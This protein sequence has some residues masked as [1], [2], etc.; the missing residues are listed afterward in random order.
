MSSCIA[1]KKLLVGPVSRRVYRRDPVKPRQNLT[2]FL[3]RDPFGQRQLAGL[4]FAFVAAI[5]VAL[6]VVESIPVIKNLIGSK[7]SRA[8]QTWDGYKA[9]AGSQPGT[10][11]DE[12]GF[13]EIVKG[14]FDAN[15]SALPQTTREPLLRDYAAALVAGIKKGA[16]PVTATVDQIYAKIGEPWLKTHVRS[17]AEFQKNSKLKPL[18]VDLTTRYLA[19]LPITR[20]DMA[21]FKGDKAYTVHAPLI[22]TALKG[23]TPPTP[24]ATTPAKTPA[25]KPPVSKP[26]A[27]GSIPKTAS[28]APDLD[29]LVKAFLAQGATQNQAIQGALQALQSAGIAT[30]AA[31]QAA[32]AQEAAESSQEM[33]AAGGPAAGIPGWMVMA[34]GG[35]AVVFALARPGGRRG[36][37]KRGRAR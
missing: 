13:A 3:E 33:L 28:G 5:P 9:V 2:P 7:P 17:W 4:G 32:V 8:E 19:N 25:K 35:L 23:W 20:A 10:A 34:A 36:S 15:R 18:F 37:K 6:K 11:Y 22:L 1:E 31:V 27:A 21:A 12:R 14:G 16:V 26:P 29:A 30:P 24:K